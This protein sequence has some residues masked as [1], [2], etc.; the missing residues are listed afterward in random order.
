MLV[1]YDNKKDTLTHHSQK[2][3][4]LT[5]YISTYTSPVF[6]GEMKK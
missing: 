5:I 6:V 3:T 4:L 2:W 1:T